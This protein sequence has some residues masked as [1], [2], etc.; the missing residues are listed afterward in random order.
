L[1]VQ[2]TIIRIEGYGP[3]TITLGSD[4]EAKLQMLQA[5][6]YHDLQRLFSDKDSLV[7]PNRFDEYFAITNGLS[8]RDHAEIECELSQIYGNLA[9]SMAIGSG[10][11]PFQ[12][13]LEAYNSR[14]A[15]KPV[16]HNNRILAGG[17]IP[18]ISSNSIPNIDDYVMLLHID[19]SNSANISSRFSPYEITCIIYRVYCRLAEEFLKKDS[20]TF[21]LGGDNFMVVSSDITKQ[22][23]RSTIN[24]VSNG[25]NIRLNCGIGIGRTGRKAASAATKALDT[26]RELRNDGKHMPVYEV[27]CL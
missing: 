3:W 15:C 20:L 24:K 10:M 8:V 12:A 14:K 27:S 26:I 11:T 2:L 9:L 4:R 22:E 1:T 7:Y 21:F 18:L 13:N 17:T 16:P 23:V 25:L 5:S 19:M 6:F